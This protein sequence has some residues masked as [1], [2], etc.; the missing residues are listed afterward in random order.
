MTEMH[1]LFFYLAVDFIK[2]FRG[3]TIGQV[4]LSWV[5]VRVKRE[6]VQK[7]R[8]KLCHTI[9]SSDLEGFTK[10]HLFILVFIFIEVGTTSCTFDYQ[11]LSTSGLLIPFQMHT[12]IF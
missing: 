9:I 10:C 6:H 7:S 2:C 5:V 11:L 8:N 3:V 4:K 12:V 1:N